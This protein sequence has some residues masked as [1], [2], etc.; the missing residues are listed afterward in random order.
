MITNLP[1]A[2][3]AAIVFASVG[4]SAARGQLGGPARPET[5]LVNQEECRAGTRVD[6]AALTSRSLHALG[7][8]TVGDRV[9]HFKSR[10]AG[11][12][13]EQSDRWY[14][15][16]L[17][18]M[19]ARDVWVDPRA[20][21][22]RHTFDT[23]WPGSGG[24]AGTVVLSQT[25]TFAVRDTVMTPLPPSNIMRGARALDPWVVVLDWSKDTT[26]HFARE[27]L[28]R[29][30]WRVVLT[31]DV[32]EGKEE[33][34]IDP[35]SGYP[36]KLQYDEPHFLWGQLRVE[37]VYTTWVVPRGG[38]S[39]PGSVI[40]VEDGE[41]V[42]NRTVNG[43]DIALVPRDS[44][45]RF[46]I[47]PATPDMRRRASTTPAVT[48]PQVAD[49]VRVGAKTYLLITPAYT[50]T[51]TLQR[52]TVF[53]LDATTSEARARGDSIWIARLF[54]GKHPI[55]VVVTD[56][57]WPH[58]GGV[59]FWVARGASIITH[60]ASV[61]FLQRLTAQRWTLNPDALEQ[62]TA[63]RGA[64]LRVRSLADTLSLGGGAVRLYAI[65]GAG[66]EGA[67]MAFIPSEQYL[68]A[69]DFVQILSRPTQYAT[70]VWTAAK[71]LGIAP[72]RFAA[73][74][75]PLTP[76]SKLADVNR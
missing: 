36:V 7:L 31:R 11:S 2:L 27:C 4:V 19:V 44:A 63:K 45:P 71:R 62:S 72:E 48:A 13:R 21:A 65:D 17:N 15:P 76:W 67:L 70:E 10:E 3:G 51:V 47:P 74:H 12:A 38:G 46:A 73:E 64:N 28:Y 42:V 14:P 60:R 24:S 18:A 54:P 40:R 50:E 20:A 52:D 34:Y 53:L 30:Y 69:S 25:A 29:D 41:A 9:L 35:R 16:Y 68:W 66:S 61:G 37:N 33:L 56:L 32:P 59:R 58:V 75:V 23:F 8:D 39:Y 5:P 1:K 22:E 55:A 43:R 57:A 49:T 6:P 26:V